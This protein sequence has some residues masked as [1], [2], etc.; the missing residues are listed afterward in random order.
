MKDEAP[1]LI[2]LNGLEF[3]IDAIVNG[4]GIHPP[5]VSGKTETG[6]MG[7]RI[8]LYNERHSKRGDLLL[9]HVQSI[10]DNS[11]E[12][13]QTSQKIERHQSK[14]GLPSQDEKGHRP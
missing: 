3:E 2:E 10:V 6:R 12:Q 1:V 7:R 4:A 8:R 14:N 5:L 9:S 11:Q 13:D